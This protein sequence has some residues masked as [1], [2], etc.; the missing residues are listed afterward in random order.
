MNPN[1]HANLVGFL[2]KQGV[3]ALFIAAASVTTVCLARSLT[4]L[5]RPGETSTMAGAPPL[6]AFTYSMRVPGSHWLEREVARLFGDAP[7]ECVPCHEQ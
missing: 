5:E 3:Q 7:V 6:K 1:W 4:A 2:P